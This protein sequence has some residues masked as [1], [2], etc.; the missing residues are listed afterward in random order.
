[1]SFVPS[2]DDAYLFIKDGK[3]KDFGKMQELKMINT[4]QAIDALSLIHI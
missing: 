3:I 1:M 2:I 4:D